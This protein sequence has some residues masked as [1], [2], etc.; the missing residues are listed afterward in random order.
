MAFDRGC[1]YR[2]DNLDNITPKVY[3]C[4]DVMQSN[5]LMVFDRSCLYRFDNRHKVIPKV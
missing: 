2:F 3:L 5:T 1:L 4:L